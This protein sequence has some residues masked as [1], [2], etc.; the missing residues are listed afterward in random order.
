MQYLSQSE[1][2]MLTMHSTYN[3]IANWWHVQ[4][5]HNSCQVLD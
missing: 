2:I 5:K 1:I 4:F 3:V